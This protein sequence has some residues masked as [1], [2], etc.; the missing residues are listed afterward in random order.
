MLDEKSRRE[1]EKE[2][3]LMPSMRR[4]GILP[5]YVLRWPRIS[6]SSLTPPSDNRINFLPS[7]PAIDEA[8]DVLPAATQ[9]ELQYRLPFITPM[10]CCC[11]LQ[12]LK[13][14]NQD[15]HITNSWRPYEAKHR[16]SGIRLKLHRRENAQIRINQSEHR[17]SRIEQELPL[18]KTNTS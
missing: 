3:T 5:M 11:Q 14:G 15:K 8:N 2:L 7:A 18:P 13:A 1:R 6:A 17:C 9:A 4:P 12:H 16:S 10:L